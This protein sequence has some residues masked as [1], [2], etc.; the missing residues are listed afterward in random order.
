M[1]RQFCG[2]DWRFFSWRVAPNLICGGLG[3][4]HAFMKFLKK[5]DLMASTRA[6]LRNFAR[7]AA[8]SIGSGALVLDAGAGDSPY[9][10]YFDHATY[11]AADHCK[12]PERPYTH[13]SYVCD[14]TS[15]PVES[16]RYDLVLCTQVLE[17]VPRPQETLKEFSRVLKSG[18]KLW[19]S[20]PFFYEEHEVPH[21][22][23][24]Y[25]QFAW[26]HMMEQAGLRIDRLNWVSGYY[27]T[28]AY[29]LDMAWHS[30]PM[31]PRHFG[32]GFF[33]W[34]ASALITAVRPVMLGL[35]FIFSRLD[36]RHKYTH[37]G[38]TLDYCV[39]ASKVDRTE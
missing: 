11:E 3:A 2:I 30:L 24:R 29:Q 26:R 32:G 6:N 36:A 18:G 33:G 35:A 37:A 23:F 28:L 9:R 14:L 5:P 16:N 38:H 1:A 27:G 21:D 17:H 12:R 4:G 31:R 13:V 25:T 10:Q 15:I 20:A 39:V 8:A 19:I 7:E 34:A 22:F